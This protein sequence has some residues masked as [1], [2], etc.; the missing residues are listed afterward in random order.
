LLG[1]IDLVLSKTPETDFQPVVIDFKTG[2]PPA[3]KDC[4]GAESVELSDFQLPLYIT[5]YE[6]N[7]GVQ[8]SKQTAVSTALF[9]SINKAESR[10][11]IG[12]L[13][14]QVT[15]KT[16]PAKDAIE[17]D[18]PAYTAI[19][20]EVDAKVAQYATVLWTAMFTHAAKPD[21]K[22][23]NEC[24]HR[25]SCRTTYTVARSQFEELAV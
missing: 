13:V 4:V 18:D 21:W 16:T 12:S 6:R 14:N 3:R 22:T 5:L 7:A 10:V 23:C 15:G 8:P 20:D 1:K 19:M 9:F 25:F 17:R 2:N 24:A 11:I